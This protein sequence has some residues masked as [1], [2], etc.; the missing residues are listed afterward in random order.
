[1][2]IQSENKQFSEAKKANSIESLISPSNLAE[3]KRLELRSR[4]TVDTHLSGQYK[5]AFRG[6]GLVFS[7]LREYTPG[8]DVK[9]IHW[10]IT[11]RSGKV[12]IKSY[13]EDRELNI[14]I[15]LDVSSSTIAGSMKSKHQ[16]GLEFCAILAMLAKL[17]MDSLGLCLFS[18]KVEQFLPVSKSRMQF[19]RVLLELLQE[20]KL[21]P[22]TDLASSIDFLN[23]NLRKTSVVFLISDFFSTAYI[24][25]LRMLSLK[26]DVVSVMLED[27]LDYDLPS[28][29]LV[30]FQD[31]ESGEFILLD[32]SNKKTRKMLS[33]AHEKRIKE[34]EELCK[35]A[36]CDYIRI[37]QNP[38]S[39]L[40]KLIAK[41]NLRLR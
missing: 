14:V 27:R 18:D 11:A 26:H 23:K 12:Y 25:Q 31:P 22:D 13:E 8:D 9:H 33:L 10:K 38:I 29:G 21:T 28:A 16:R 7:D 15:A 34:W 6:T 32:S 19:K 35:K 20:R 40:H 30:E 36:N 4:R 39:S 2:S 41:R 1:M 24:D 17:N 3:L 37:N 5:S